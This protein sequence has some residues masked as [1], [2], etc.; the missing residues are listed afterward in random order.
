MVDRSTMRIP[1]PA[2]TNY[3]EKLLLGIR[4]EDVKLTQSGQF[5]GKVSL[6]EPLG[7]ETIVH[8][9]AGEQT[10]LSIVPGTAPYGID[11]DIQFD[12]ASDR[13]HVF[14]LDGSRI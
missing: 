10:L 5:T 2:R 4:P 1:I 9:R 12:L 8:I 11:N 13:L 6:V 14:G 7:V 3:P